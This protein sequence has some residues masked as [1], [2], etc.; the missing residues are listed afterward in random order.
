[1]ASLFIVP[2]CWQLTLGERYLVT[3]FDYRD[4]VG[5]FSDYVGL[6]SD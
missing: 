2:M 3:L 6:S 1:M 4:Y 5:L